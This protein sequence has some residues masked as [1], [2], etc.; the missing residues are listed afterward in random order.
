[1]AQRKWIRLGTTRL[2]VW[3]LAS[4]CRS[5]IRHC[6]ELW[7]RSQTQ[8]GYGVAV[9]VAW[10]G[11]YSFVQTLTWEPPY[12]TGAALKKEN[13]FLF[14]FWLTAEPH[15][16]GIPEIRWGHVIDLWLVEYGQKKCTL[17]LVPWDPSSVLSFFLFCLPA[18][19]MIDPEEGSKALQDYGATNWKK[20]ELLVKSIEKI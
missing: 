5:R 15:F 11:G 4:L 1:M 18:K 6:H 3:S 17:L 19:W 8:L 14:L 20:P 13:A 10:A 7:C 12:A 16:L 9:A 2:Q